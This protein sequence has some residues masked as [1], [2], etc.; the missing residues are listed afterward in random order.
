MK[1]P[2]ELSPSY[3]HARTPTHAH[4]HTLTL[5]QTHT[6][7]ATHLQTCRFVKC[8]DKLFLLASHYTKASKV[9]HQGV[10]WGGVVWI[11]QK[12]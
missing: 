11:N 8:F 2:D 7:T 10:E 4:T 5:Q 3:T 12:L 1:A 9:G 6:P